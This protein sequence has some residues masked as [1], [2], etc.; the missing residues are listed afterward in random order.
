MWKLHGAVIQPRLPAP[1]A[2]ILEGAKVAFS[3]AHTVQAADSLTVHQ[4]ALQNEATYAILRC[5]IASLTSDENVGSTISF[6][7]SR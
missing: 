1:S 2:R 5:G 7:G 6:A 3:T 4:H